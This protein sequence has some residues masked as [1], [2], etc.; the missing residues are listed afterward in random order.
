MLVVSSVLSALFI[1]FLELIVLLIF[2][3]IV[4]GSIGWKAVLLLPLLMMNIYLVLSIS[5][6]LATVGVYFLDITR[7]W[8]ILMNIGIF[9]TPIFY[10]MDMLSPGK[11]R[12]IQLNPMTHIIKATR[13]IMIGN[14]YPHPQ[15]LVYVL[16]LSTVLMVA[17]YKMFKA[18]EGYFVEKI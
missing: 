3:L 4:K 9:I 8:G 16:I 1:H 13:D 12:I 2:W 17:G 15:G 10:S 6:I 18:R 14:A 5:F 11:Q 7:I